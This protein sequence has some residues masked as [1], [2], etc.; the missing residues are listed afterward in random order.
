LI[1]IKTPARFF[2]QYRCRT[3][4]ERVMPLDAILVAAMTAAFCIFAITLCWADVRGRMP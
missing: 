3:T 4:K 2:L 1:E